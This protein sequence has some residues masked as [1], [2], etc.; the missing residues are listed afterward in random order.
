[1][2]SVE[3]EAHYV[4]IFKYFIN[5]LQRLGTN[6][7]KFSMNPSTCEMINLFYKYLTIAMYLWVIEKVTWKRTCYEETAALSCIF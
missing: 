7:L 6:L 3:E 2:A 4:D 1:M 5:S